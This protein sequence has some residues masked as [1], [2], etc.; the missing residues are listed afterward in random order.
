MKRCWY[1]EE[2]GEVRKAKDEEIA[3][4][5]GFPTQMRCPIGKETSAKYV[6]LKL[7][8]YQRNP[9]EPIVE[10]ADRLKSPTTDRIRL[11][12]A[13]GALSK[14]MAIMEGKP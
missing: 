1:I 4:V 12:V 10:A 5:D 9:L 3:L 2:T 13:E 7:T 6:I 11:L 14:C 8:E